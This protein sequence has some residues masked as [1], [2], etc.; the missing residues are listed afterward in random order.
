MF[1]DNY[2]TGDAK[3]VNV[4]EEIPGGFNVTFVSAGGTFN[5]ATNI[6]TWEIQSIGSEDFKMLN[7]ELVAPQTAGNY[8]INT[9]IEYTDENGT[10]Y[11]AINISKFIIVSGAALPD[12]TLTSED[13]WFIPPASSS[14]S[15]SSPGQTTLTKDIHKPKSDPNILKNVKSAQPY[16]EIGP[17]EVMSSSDTP[18]FTIENL[19]YPATENPNQ[20]FQVTVDTNYSFNATTDI[21]VG[22]WDY[23]AW[24]YIAETPDNETLSGTGSKSYTFNLTAP[25]SGIMH[26]SADAC[27]GD[28]DYVYYRD[29]EVTISTQSFTIENLTYPPTV[30]PNQTFQVTVHTN[31]S[32]ENITYIYVGIWD[33]DASEY[34]AGTPI[35]ETTLSGS[36]NIS[37]TLNLTA[38]LSGIMNLS[39]DLCYWDDEW[40]LSD[41][42]DFDVNISAE[43]PDFTI[44]AI[45]TSQTVSQGDPAP[46]TIS[47]TSL[48][49]FNSPVTL[50]VSGLPTGATSIFD[51]N[52]VTPSDSAT[53]TINTSTTTPTGNYTLTITG[54]G[55]EIT[56]RT[57]VALNITAT[58]EGNI[59][60]I[61]ATIHNIGTA[62]ANN[63]TVQFFDGDPDAGGI[64]I[65]DDQ[66]IASI[67]AGGEGT[68]SVDWTPE[69][70]AHAIYVWVDP[71]DSIQESNEENNIAFNT[72]LLGIKGDL[73]NDGKI[74]PADAAI[75]LA[76]AAG[77]YPLD[78]ATLAAADVSGDE[79]VTSLD[80]LMIVQ[81]ATGNIEL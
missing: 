16:K 45:P 65:G 44:A 17:R 75:T 36:G 70:N 55:G 14:T 9:T 79:Q 61:S 4:T 74:T 56:H 46:Y 19:T 35:P 15:P 49:G 34:I 10:V 29:F 78:A 26:L 42:R 3:N 73:N 20:T 81:A 5:T 38:P 80:A 71:F 48:N 7:Y 40:N 37:Y 11:P 67:P 50:S 25:P 18:T 77:G 13:I 6:I 39:A 1:I 64:Q 32:F 62:D 72:I 43:E 60:T 51:P 52:P 58:G 22:I 27:Y 23:D 66:I 63:V 59:T 24:D 12:L 21:F 54:I 2:G 8:T 28:C 33:Y 69:T 68:V 53:L 41:Y 57:T 31:Y 76:I 47:L 30:D